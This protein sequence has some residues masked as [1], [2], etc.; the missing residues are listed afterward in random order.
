MLR[1]V[2]LVAA[3]ARD[4]VLEPPLDDCL[5]QTLPIAA[6]DAERLLP[7]AAERALIVLVRAPSRDVPVWLGRG[8][9][10]EPI[11]VQLKPQ[12]PRSAEVVFCTAASVEGDAS[13]R[14]W[15][16]FMAWLVALSFEVWVRR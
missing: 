16:H 9:S 3:L 15:S 13:P 14:T 1:M 10:G 5:K 2:L 8:N 12:K 7:L 11:R 6:A 4:A